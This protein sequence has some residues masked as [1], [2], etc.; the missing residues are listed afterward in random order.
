M[1]DRYVG[2]V[3]DFGKYGLLR[4][5][6]SPLENAPALR[7][8]VVW[9]LVPDGSANGDGSRVGYLSLPPNRAAAFRD[10]DPVLFD[11]MQRLVADGQRNV[12]SVS[13]AS[14]LP[15]GTVFYE[16]LLD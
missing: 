5:L 10:C 9:Y 13:R 7:V 16:R 15:E 1:Q 12:E 11:T 2:D 4:A 8:G 6:L 14:V 3:G